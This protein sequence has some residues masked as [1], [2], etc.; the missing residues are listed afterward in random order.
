[1]ISGPFEL[2]PQ[3][4]MW[5]DPLNV[6]IPAPRLMTVAT[7]REAMVAVPNATRLTPATRTIQYDTNPNWLLSLYGDVFS[8]SVRASQPYAS[9]T[10]C[11][12][13]LRPCSTAQKKRGAKSNTRKLSAV[14]MTSRRFKRSSTEPLPQPS[15]CGPAPCGPAV[16]FDAG[17]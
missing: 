17:A 5:P 9:P 2:Q 8:N 14:A 10:E 15:P 12:S 1:M 3:I 4:R 16:R 6:P 11:T 13:A 7:N